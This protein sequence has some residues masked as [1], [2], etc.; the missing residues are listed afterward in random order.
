[1]AGG[2]SITVYGTVMGTR[3][4]GHS[5]IHRIEATGPSGERLDLQV[6]ARKRHRG[7]VRVVWNPDGSAESRFPFEMPWPIVGLAFGIMALIVG[8][9]WLLVG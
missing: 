4:E 8:G 7:A 9:S 2:R 3:L 5:T 6:V 1:M